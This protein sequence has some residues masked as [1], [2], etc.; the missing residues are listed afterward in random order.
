MCS[1]DTV[2][3]LKVLIDT[4]V[5]ELLGGGTPTA[6]ALRQVRGAVR[7]EKQLLYVRGL[8][9]GSQPQAV[10]WRHSQNA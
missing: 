9:M 10:G 4:K 3:Q 8:R 1:T 6:T 2:K 7:V 5:K